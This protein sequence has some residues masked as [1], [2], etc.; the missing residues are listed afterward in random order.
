MTS[1][2]ID[3]DR[4]IDSQLWENNKYNWDIS[5][6]LNS[7][8]ID[9]KVLVYIKNKI[10][11]QYWK[12]DPDRAFEFLV[13]RSSQNFRKDFLRHFTLNFFNINILLDFFDLEKKSINYISNTFWNDLFCKIF[14]KDTDQL[15]YHWQSIIK[16]EIVQKCWNWDINKAYNYLW[17]I[18]S[19][20]VKQAEDFLYVQ[21]DD[22]KFFLNEIYNIFWIY[23]SDD[24]KDWDKKSWYE[25]LRAI[26]DS[27][28]DV[29]GAVSPENI[30]RFIV[31]KYGDLNT[32]EALHLL[33]S[34]W[35]KWRQKN[36]KIY[37]NNKI[38]DMVTVYR[39]FHLTKTSLWLDSNALVYQLLQDG[40]REVFLS[41]VFDR[42]MEEISK[43]K[44][45]SKNNSLSSLQDMI[46]HNI[47]QKYWK[48]DSEKALD[49]LIDKWRN[50]RHWTFKVDWIA[51]R[52]RSISYILSKFDPPK[53]YQ[54][55][56]YSD[57]MRYYLLSKLFNKS[58]LELSSLHNKI[59]LKNQISMCKTMRKIMI[60]KYWDWSLEQA[61]SFLAKQWHRWRVEYFKIEIDGKQ[62]WISDIFTKAWFTYDKYNDVRRNEYRLDFLTKVFGKSTQ[63]IQ[64]LVDKRSL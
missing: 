40:P 61:L 46:K 10:S 53:H 28:R 50:R 20:D 51:K 11:L 14:W 33:L 60:K 54:D 49:Y 16:K 9:D 37:L 12:W 6:I 4:L 31:D 48:W 36:F 27:D 17:E 42:S 59:I 64:K 23:V 56:P 18:A 3:N 44:S 58:L 52:E 21:I 8:Q 22:K 45:S 41:K 13:S 19:R 26:F 35:F 55:D 2:H 47:I 15:S 25:L 34:K 43:L 29:I 62:C 63:K 39:C 30:K 7:D 24:K 5:S 1:E 32:E 38:I 57:E